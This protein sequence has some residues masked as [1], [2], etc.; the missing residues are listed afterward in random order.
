MAG[1]A[2]AAGVVRWRGWMLGLCL[3]FVLPLYSAERRLT[4][5]ELGARNPSDFS[6]RFAG[7]TVVVRGV[8]NATAFHFTD[9]NL[10]SIEDQS[11][12]GVLK[13]AAGD[14]WLDS[15]HPGDEIEAQGKVVLQYG[16]P[17]LAPENILLV[18]RKPVPTAI[19]VSA[20]KA[21]DLKYLGRLIRTEATITDPPT[22]N[23]GGALIILGASPEPYRVFIPRAT[24]QPKANLSGMRKGDIIRV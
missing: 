15:F 6:A 20:S 14:A 8:V 17:M 18:G 10:L 9:Y 24:G 21:Q 12:G 3:A 23:A 4:L 22:Y 16:L 19:D 11:Y 2:V 7:Q 13:V 1:S 5:Q